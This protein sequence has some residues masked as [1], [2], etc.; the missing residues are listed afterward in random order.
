M[1][2]PYRLSMTVQAANGQ[3][4]KWGPD[5]PDGRD[6]PQDIETT[7]SLPG[8]HGTCTSSLFRDIRIDYADNNVLDTVRLYGPG[9]REATDGRKSVFEGFMSSFPRQ[10]G[11]QFSI[12]PGAVGFAAALSFFPGFQRIYVDR[13]SGSW[14]DPPFNRKAGLAG[15]AIDFGSFSWSSDGG[16]LVC[17]L[18]NQA[19]GAS[20]IAETWYQSPAGLNIG[21]FKYIGADTSL[22]A[23]W[24]APKLFIYADDALSAGENY[25]LTLDS[26]LRSVTPTTARRYAFLREYSAGAAAT[27]AAGAN[28]R[29][30]A[31]AVYGDH[32]ITTRAIDATTPDGLYN[33]DI[34]A[35]ILAQTVPG[36]LNWTTGTGGSIEPNN[37]I[38]PHLVFSGPGT[39][40]DALAKAS[41]FGI[42]PFLL[43]EWGV[44]DNRTFFWRSPDSSRLCWK[45][46][47]DSGIKPRF[48]GETADDVING[49][50]VTFSDPA[51]ITR[52]VGPPAQYWPTG[53]AIADS[54]DSSLVDTD[55]ANPINEHADSTG[56]VKWGTLQ[57]SQPCTTAGA[58]AL[59]SMFLAIQSQ[60][61][62]RGQIEISGLVGHPT[63]TQGQPVY[64]MRAGDWL[65]LTDSESPELRRR[66]IGTRYSHPS[67]SITC[68]LDNRPFTLD[69]LLEVLQ[70]DLVSLG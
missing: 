24:E 5:S 19:L 1:Q 12:E 65:Q 9:S 35:D 13:S 58:I 54:T 61:Q 37:T 44:Y 16:G 67:R 55:P 31:V 36:V 50:L 20:V 38:V 2:D 25:A 30:S 41:G 4:W 39:A 29:F 59:G 62:R 32:G 21:G 34:V 8:G 23:S 7:T 70:A 69:A 18:P 46:R 11:A 57:L 28:R 64:K 48:D 51:G 6:V 49:V 14:G 53:V 33:C 68:D 45:A 10:H 63:I 40:Q 26:T 3:T 47:Y 15:L 27:P 56:G 60:P 52:V 22:P 43:P 17:A 66:I 42:T